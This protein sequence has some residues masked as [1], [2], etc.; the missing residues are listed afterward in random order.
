MKK[1]VLSSLLGAMAVAACTSTTTSAVVACGPDNVATTNAD[2]VAAA[3]AEAAWYYASLDP[4]V[5]GGAIVADVPVAADPDGGITLDAGFGLPDG[6]FSAA[7]AAA[8]SAV[9]AAAGNYFQNGCAT[10]TASGNVVTF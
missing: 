10:A 5:F 1:V 2:V 3:N 7:S 8:A 9:A 6:G 4:I